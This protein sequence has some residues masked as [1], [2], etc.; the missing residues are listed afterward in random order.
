MTPVP[1]LSVVVNWSVRGSW[2]EPGFTVFQELVNAGVDELPLL[3]GQRA[4]LVVGDI[5]PAHGVAGHLANRG[6]LGC[7]AGGGGG[8]ADTVLGK[9][10]GPM[11]CAAGPSE[12]FLTYKGQQLS[13]VVVAWPR[14]PPHHRAA[15]TE[16]LCTQVLQP[17][18]GT[19]FD[20]GPDAAEIWRAVTRGGVILHRLIA[21][22]AERRAREDRWVGALEQTDVPLS[23][24]WGM[25][26]PISGAHVAQRIRERLP[27]APL[28]ALEDVGHWPPLEAPERVV[29]A[30]SR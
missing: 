27:D 14:P 4:G 21:Y 12:T 22:M 23:F 8:S 28:T 25:L 24:V 18:W 30:L 9:V 26:D 15:M 1:E 2:K 7:G 3:V 20:G 5:D 6:L 13:R 10:D 17:T 29:A 16:E 11:W 19:G